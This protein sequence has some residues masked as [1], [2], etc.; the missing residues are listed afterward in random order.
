MS[1]QRRTGAAAYGVAATRTRT[2]QRP[3]AVPPAPGTPDRRKYT[4][5]ID[6]GPADRFEQAVLAL[7]PDVGRKL[8]KSEVMRELAELLADDPTVAKKVAD[9]LRRHS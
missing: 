1:P 9:R 8:D 4:V 6:A 3:V 2:A 5:R 7:S